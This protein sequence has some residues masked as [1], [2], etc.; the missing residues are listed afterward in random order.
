MIPAQL[1]EDIRNKADIVKVVSEY[2]KLKKRGKNYLGMCPF[3][4]EKD[5]SFTVSPEKQIFHCFGCNEGGNAYAF[6]MKMENIGFVD[7]VA[8]LG[9]KVGISVPKV[10]SRG[11]SRSDKD[12]LYQVTSLAAKYYQACLEDELGQLA[13][14]YLAKRKIDPKT[15]EAFG[16]GYAP[17][18][19]DNLFKHLI[20]RGVAPEQI[21]RA[22]L[23]LKRE[24]KQGYYD[25]FR[26][27][28]IFPVLDHRGRVVAFGGRALG[29]EEPKYL[30]SPDTALYHKG[31][32]LFGLNLSKDQIKKS[33]TAIMVEGN[34]DLITPYQAGFTNAIASMGTALTSYQCKLLSRYCD[35]I[36]LAFDADAAGGKAAERSIE[37]LKNQGLK[38]KVA[39]LV[40]GK[41]PDEVIN[42]KGA[43][44]FKACLDSALPYLE[45]KLKIVLKRHNLKEIESRSKALRES[46]AILA[47]ETDDFIKKEYAKRLATALRT[48]PETVLAEVKRLGHYPKQGQKNLRRMT[49]KP[50]SKVAEAEKH[51]IALAVQKPELLEQIKERLEIGDFNQPETRA[52]ASLLFETEFKGKSSVHWLLDNVPDE[53]A[54]K[55]LSRQMIEDLSVEEDKLVE[56][57]NDCISVLKNERV[58]SRITELK[59]EI[60]E[61]EASG[62]LDKAAKLLSALKSEIS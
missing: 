53:S 52:I 3:H 1:I 28:L 50:S 41:D 19:W 55:F 35:T 16:L 14:D 11:P 45:F 22:G 37:L 21:E 2:V 10:A 30:N 48:E 18:G 54:K 38:V 58:R 59:L 47:Q 9:E 44:G 43:E 12:K 42:N 25:R 15:K 5:P 29:D 56:M 60:K 7:A 46:A 39:Q 40:G 23:V 62:Q 34:F 4:Q 32:T 31:E 51:L 27:R 61:A 49:E 33:R 8:E 6:L 57:M 24:G 36:V 17:P 20:S 26:D 13:R